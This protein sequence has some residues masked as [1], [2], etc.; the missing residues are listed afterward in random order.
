MN[1][2][3]LKT[4]NLTK[5][6]HGS[7]ALED[8]SVSLKAGRIY[9]LI[10]QNGAG[11]T[12]LMRIM[13]GH[14]FP[15]NGSI[16]LFGKVDEKQLPAERKRLGCIIES[17]SYLPNLSAMDNL[18]YYRVVRGIPNKEICQEVLDITGLADTGT[19]KVK[20]FSLGMR[21]RLGI[22]I[23]LLGNP[24]LLILDEPINGLDPLGVIEI[25][26]LLKKLCEEQQI[27]ILISSH[28]LPEMYQ[29]ATD[30]IF[31]H[32][33]KLIQTLSA[34]QLDES[35]RHYLHIGCNAPEKACS[36][37]ESVLQTTNYK[38]M[39]DQTIR[40][41]DCLDQKE[42]VA[43]ALFQN[44]IIILEFTTKGDTLENYFLSIIGGTQHA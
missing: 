29:T 26:K 34:E 37:L 43:T 31:I 3:I 28:N 11:K 42:Q 13:T 20:N 9:G 40:L 14:S 39:P 38:V 33:G 2:Y 35:C 15:T 25:R 18:Q 22:A 10:G 41:Y 32:H 17:P 1:D 5:N 7:N 16:E 44:E 27:T 6:Y 19:K 36:V 4:N 21:Q 8:F 30:Y 12:T 23:A 24:E